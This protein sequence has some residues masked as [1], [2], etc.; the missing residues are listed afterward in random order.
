MK[1]APGSEGLSRDPGGRQQN[2]NEKSTAVA[3][4]T[5]VDGSGDRA[6]TGFLKQST[7]EGGWDG[8]F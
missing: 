8:T 1:E 5:R 7:E 4:Q 6:E 2:Q 3:R